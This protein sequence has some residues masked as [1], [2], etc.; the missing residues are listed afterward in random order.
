MTGHRVTSPMLLGVKTEGQLGG[1]DELMQAFEIIPKH[2]CKT[3][4]EH[5]LKT[6]EKILLVNDIQTDLQIVHLVLL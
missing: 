3:Y 1:R 2:S 6:L 5:I 4:Q